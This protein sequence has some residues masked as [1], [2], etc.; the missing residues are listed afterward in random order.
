MVIGGL[1]KQLTIDRVDE[2]LTVHDHPLLLPSRKRS[3][4]CSDV[5]RVDLRSVL[6]E[7]HTRN[8]R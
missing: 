1:L 2:T 3:F 5:R 4:P 7:E 6:H 8:E